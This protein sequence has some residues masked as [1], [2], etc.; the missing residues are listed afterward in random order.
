RV[1]A[2]MDEHIVPRHAQWL[3]EAHAGHFPASFMEEL[4][5]KAKSEGLW[6]LFLPHLKNDEP[7]TA[8]TNLEYAPLA[9]IMGRISW[10]PEVFNCNA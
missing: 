8:L 7:G 5:A 6:N 10:A 4:K 3:D 1:R 9:E 2:F